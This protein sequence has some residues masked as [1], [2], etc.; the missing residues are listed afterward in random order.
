MVGVARQTHRKARHRG[1]AD[2][3]SGSG[4]L[5]GKPRFGNSWLGRHSLSVA[6]IVLLLLQSYAFYRFRLP[7][8]ISDQQ[9]HGTKNPK[10]WPGFWEHYWGEYMVSILAD[11]YGA[12][13]LVLFSKWFFEQGSAESKDRDPEQG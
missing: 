11:T 5:S 1:A 2:L 8:W 6:L 3:S 9:A 12:L 4:F 13:I 10:V 7:E